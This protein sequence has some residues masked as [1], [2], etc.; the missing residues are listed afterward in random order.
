M[1]QVFPKANVHAAL[2]SIFRHNVLTFE[3]GTMGAINGMRSDGTKDLTSMQSDE[4][5]VGVSYSLASIMVME[6]R[7]NQSL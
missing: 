6:V 4:F 7:N 2:D 5:W 1:F 3:G